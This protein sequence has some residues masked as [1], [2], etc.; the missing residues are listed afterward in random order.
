MSA[1]QQNRQLPCPHYPDCASC[2][3]IGTPYGE[4][5]ARKRLLT[6]D[7]V[8]RYESLRHVEVPPLVGSPRAFGYR[9]QVKL[10]PR[11]SRHGLLLGVYRPGTH[12]VVDVSSCPVHEPLINRVLA[13]IRREL[14]EQDP[15]IYDERRRTGWLRYVV[16]RTSRWKKCAQ[17]VLVVRARGHRGTRRL[18]SAVRRIRGVRSVLLNVNAAPGNEARRGS[19]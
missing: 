3:W 9:N 11:R 16:V 17:V 4:Q 18:T 13:A 12:Q 8:H 7:A 19:V 1:R 15:P 5:L 14:E 6:C 10:V 2:A